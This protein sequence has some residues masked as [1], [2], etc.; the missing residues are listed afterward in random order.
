M[1]RVGCG[2]KARLNYII[3]EVAE[4]INVGERSLYQKVCEHDKS[5]KVSS[6]KKLWRGGAKRDFKKIMAIL[7]SVYS[8]GF[9]QSI[10]H[11]N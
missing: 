11:K 7:T 6:S 8:G 1:V 4:L 3:K 5:G 10:F 2:E 9:V